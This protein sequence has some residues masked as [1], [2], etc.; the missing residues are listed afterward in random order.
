MTKRALD[1]ALSV[2][3][4]LVALPLMA[5]AAGAIVA[6][7]R[8]PAIFR[9]VRIGIDRKPFVIFKL[10]TMGADAESLKPSLSHLNEAAGPFFKIADDPRITRVG[11]WLRRTSIDELP[12]LWNVL[13]GDMSLVGPRPLLE[14]EANA[15]PPE[16]DARFSARPGIT[17]LWQ[18]EGRRSSIHAQRR[19]EL[20]CEYLRC[21]SI[22]GDLRLLARTFSVIMAGR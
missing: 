15:L 5:V 19:M 16:A 4:L 17:G 10:R 22:S 18:V 1:I 12:Q 7:S 9:Q 8:G 11:R 20:D 3:L 2:V 13:R 14:A 21:P 6:D